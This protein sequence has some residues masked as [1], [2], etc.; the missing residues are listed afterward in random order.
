METGDSGNGTPG[1]I[2]N[3]Q[4]MKHNKRKTPS[5]AMGVE[6]APVSLC[7]DGG[8]SMM[9]TEE[10][11]IIERELVS[12]EE[13][14]YESEDDNTL[15]MHSRRVSLSPISRRLALQFDSISILAPVKPSRSKRRKTFDTSL[16]CF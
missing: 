15:P 14:G 9:D 2:T 5:P 8:T 12:T 1:K 13:E 4:D 3:I 10:E 6:P 16:N 7:G 11:Q